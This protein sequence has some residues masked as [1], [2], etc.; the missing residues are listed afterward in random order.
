MDTDQSVNSP[1]T[2]LRTRRPEDRA[3]EI[4]RAALELFVTRGFAA[5][6]L[7]D[8][9]KVAAVSKGLPYLYFKNKE[10]LFK[11]VI[12]EAIGGPLAEAADMISRFEGT[13]EDLLRELV[14]GFRVFEESPAGGVVKLILAEAG[15]FPD[16]ARF[17]CTHFD[18]RARE[19]FAHAL[20]R[21]VQRK[22]F[23]P[24]TDIET[25]AVILVQPLAM[26]S[27]WKRSLAPYDTPNR[28]SSDQF[29]TAYLDFIFKGL[30]P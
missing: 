14:A 17:F 7:A 4:A 1:E 12:T 11:A 25:T 26:F 29:Y 28:L 6:K 15:N 5:T 21:G 20:R 22:E 13:S 30:R 24:I 19:L 23:R 9:A 10:E 16:V 18:M 8:V 2:T 3:P 27:V